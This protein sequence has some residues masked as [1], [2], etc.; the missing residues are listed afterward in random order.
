MSIGNKLYI[1]FAAMLAAII[2]IGGYSYL[3]M[4]QLQAS[5]DDLI[6]RR[7]VMLSDLK[8]VQTQA[9]QQ[10]NSYRDF[11][12]TGNEEALERMHTSNTAAAEALER[13][14]QQ[15]NRTE[16]KDQLNRLLEINSEIRDTGSE[17][18]QYSSREQIL[19]EAVEHLF[20]IARA[21]STAADE[22][23]A[24]QQAFMDQGVADNKALVAEIVEHLITAVIIAAAAA[25]AAGYLMARH[26]S[27]PLVRL[28][29]A[30]QQIAAGDLRPFD[31][32]VRN[33]DEIGKLAVAFEQMRSE[34]NQLIHKLN[35]SAEQ[36][37]TSSEE[38]TASAGQTADAAQHIAAAVQE[39]TSS[40][41]SQSKGT[42]ECVTAMGEMSAGL[43]RIAESSSAVAD[44][45]AD[46][47]N[48][49]DFSYGSLLH[50]VGRI[51]DLKD[52]IQT[53]ADQMEELNTYSI[54]IS[55]IVR[56]ISDIAS[57][58]NL[59]SLN[60]AIEAARAGD[61]GR[62]F[63]VVASEV[64][65]LSEMTGQ[66]ANQVEALIHEIQQRISGMT[67]TILASVAASDSSV[68]AVEEASS[69]FAVVK[70]AM[71]EAVEQIQEVSAASEE[72]SAGSEQIL[73]SV[74]E[75]ARIALTV[76]GRTQT[77]AAGTQ[78][79]LAS[80]EETKAAAESLSGLA[81][82]LHEEVNR[83]TIR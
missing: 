83:F 26:L 48:R 55:D 64:R 43:Q 4:K 12:L 3:N 38:L 18:L 8:T 29:N 45:A 15:S 13:I 72:V 74:E 51:G 21:M 66:S 75:V 67:Q 20:P 54:Q 56:I 31:T 25:A 53:A 60:A 62:G 46:T 28:A 17:I 70:S 78:E 61:Q 32:R 23:A 19:N 24:D 30:A 1:S 39:V 65:K 82:E 16:L 10:N 52:S 36:L 44:I 6:E 34:L 42:E 11:L 79:Q 73:A 2:I 33:K 14:L 77:I 76:S 37:S 71:T 69:A 5:Y 81:E 7:A 40:S 63:A 57:Q 47:R 59:L 27:R 68:Q 80:M 58:T 22:L 9:I 49:V 50:T 41:E 35:A